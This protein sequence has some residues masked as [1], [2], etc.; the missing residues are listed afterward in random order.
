M[1]IVQD[2]NINQ[3]R[4]ISLGTEKDSYLAEEC[5]GRLRN[6]RNIA[7][8]DTPT[9]HAMQQIPPLKQPN[10]QNVDLGE[11]KVDCRINHLDCM[12]AKI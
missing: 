5:L 7:N 6:P 11:P 10:N 8:S 1:K 12:V 4:F 3:N 2:Q 9:G